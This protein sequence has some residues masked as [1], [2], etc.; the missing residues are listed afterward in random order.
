MPAVETNEWVARRRLAV[1]G[2]ICNLRVCDLRADKQEKQPSCH[3]I[4]SYFGADGGL[5]NVQR[6]SMTSIGTFPVATYR[7]SLLLQLYSLVP[8]CFTEEIKGFALSISNMLRLLLVST[9][10]RIQPLICFCAG[11]GL[12]Y[13]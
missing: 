5:H 6:C 11:S 9:M 7:L 12:R 4:T 3:D 13:Y 10:R 1:A 2:S 8:K